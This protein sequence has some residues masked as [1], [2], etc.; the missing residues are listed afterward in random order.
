MK[1]FYEGLELDDAELIESLSRASYELRENRKAILELYSAADEGIVL[2]QITTGKIPAHPAY[3]HYLSVTI[4]TEMQD[5]VRNELAN[6]LRE[7]KTV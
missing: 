6:I 2:E 7:T 5:A 1:S 3:E 4:L